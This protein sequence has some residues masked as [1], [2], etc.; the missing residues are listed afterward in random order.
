MVADSWE[1]YTTGHPDN[2]VSVGAWHRFILRELEKQ[3]V[4]EGVREAFWA[5]DQECMGF[6]Q[7]KKWNEIVASVAPNL[8]K[9]AVNDAYTGLVGNNNGCLDRERFAEIMHT[10]SGSGRM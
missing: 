8:C 1:Y 4:S 5:M 9:Q 6:V 10:N 7:R 2:C 3:T